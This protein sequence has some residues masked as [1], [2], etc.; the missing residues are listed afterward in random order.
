M[1]KEDL[2]KLPDGKQAIENIWAADPVTHKPR[3]K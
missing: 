2:V 1:A 3:K